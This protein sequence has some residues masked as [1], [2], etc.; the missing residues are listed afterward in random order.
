LKSKLYDELLPGIEGDRNVPVALDLGLPLTD[1]PCLVRDYTQ[2]S[3]LCVG[4]NTVHA[5]CSPR[6]PEPPFVSTIAVYVVRIQ[7]EGRRTIRLMFTEP[8]ITPVANPHSQLRSSPV[9]WGVSSEACG[10][11]SSAYHVCECCQ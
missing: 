11:C 9:M 3:R 2:Q 8:A 6:E 10:G 4:G 7:V 1:H 5:E